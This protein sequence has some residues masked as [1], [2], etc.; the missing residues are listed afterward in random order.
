MDFYRKSQITSISELNAYEGGHN[1]TPIFK[2]SQFPIFVYVTA[3]EFETVRGNKKAMKDL[4]IQKLNNGPVDIS[5]NAMSYPPDAI[6][7]G[8]KPYKLTIK[9]E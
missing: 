9:W 5:R 7:T 3:A 1:L 8:K 4:A 6:Y 2:G